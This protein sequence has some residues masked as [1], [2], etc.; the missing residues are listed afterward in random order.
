[1][2]LSAIKVMKNASGS[3]ILAIIDSLNPTKIKIVRN[4]RIKV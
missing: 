3:N 4:T 2:T 1:M